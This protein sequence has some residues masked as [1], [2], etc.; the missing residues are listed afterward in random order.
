MSPAGKAWQWLGR[1]IPFA[2]SAATRP[3]PAGRNECLL[4][5]NRNPT[6]DGQPAI[7]YTVAGVSVVFPASALAI[8]GREVPATS[9]PT[10]MKLAINADP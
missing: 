8:H 6:D 3:Q 9:I 1:A 2:R 7:D 10:A 5:R 4:P